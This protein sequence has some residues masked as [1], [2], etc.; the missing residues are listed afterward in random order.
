MKLPFFH[1]HDLGG[2][3][4]HV[5]LSLV[6]KKWRSWVNLQQTKRLKFS[7]VLR[8]R[9]YLFAIWRKRTASYCQCQHISATWRL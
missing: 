9:G 8:V 3:Y 5:I 7:V 6:L 2:E 1:N 4:F